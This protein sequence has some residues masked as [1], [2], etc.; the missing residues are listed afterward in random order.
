MHLGSL[1]KFPFL[2]GKDSPLLYDDQNNIFIP[3]GMFTSI[4]IEIES[5]TAMCR[6]KEQIVD[7]RH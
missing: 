5:Q 2:G 4:E 3:I 6:D 1:G 7:K